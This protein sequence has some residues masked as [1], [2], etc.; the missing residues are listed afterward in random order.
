[1]FDLPVGDPDAPLQV[2]WSSLKQGTQVWADGLA[3]GEYARG[4]VFS[5]LATDLYTSPS[6]V[7]IDR[8]LKSMVLT[9]HYC[10][11]LADRVHDVGWII[12]TMDNKIEGLKKEIVDLRAGLGPK[13]IVAAK[14]R[15]AEA[16]A[17]VDDLKVE[18]EEAN[19]R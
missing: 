9:Q 3:L 13:A 2:R 7:L 1:M 4:V 11:A 12:S 15:A 14:Q 16:Q 19:R 17:L 6:E 10:M 18:L 5:V 8:A